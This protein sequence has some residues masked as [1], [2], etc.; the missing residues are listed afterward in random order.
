MSYTPTEWTSLPVKCATRQAF[1]LT[2]PVFGVDSNLKE[3]YFGYH[4]YDATVQLEALSGNGWSPLWSAVA[5]GHQ[6]WA[7]V[8]VSIPPNAELLQFVGSTGNDWH[9]G[10]SLDAIGLEPPTIAYQQVFCNFQR[11][12]CLWFNAGNYIWQPV[13]SQATGGQSLKASTETDEARTFILESPHF[14]AAANKA[15]LLTYQVTGSSSVS[16]ELQSQLETGTWTTILL[17]MGDKGNIWHAESV[18][19]PDGTV[20]LRI[21]ANV[22]GVADAVR[23]DSVQALHVAQSATDLACGFEV[24]SCSWLDTG[25]HPW[26][27]TSGS[28]YM[29]VEQALEG[30]WYV[31]NRGD[32]KVWC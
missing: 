6:D 4:L 26:Q 31:E 12:S 19:V 29:A 10:M 7:F 32:S 17:Q 25:P 23:V 24:D 21:V 13:G 14:N 3:L 9:S 8:R 1:A 22:T 5:E 30:T 2:S 11:Y 27:R 18:R 20:A 28:T 15:L 16:M